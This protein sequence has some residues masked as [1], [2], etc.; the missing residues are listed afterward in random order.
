MK[1]VILDF[2]TQE[3]H[4]YDYDLN[5]WEDCIDFIES[6][7]IGLNSNNCQWMVVDKLKL[8]IH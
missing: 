6:K 7:E 8:E 5:K 4:I 2:S 1:I 3:I